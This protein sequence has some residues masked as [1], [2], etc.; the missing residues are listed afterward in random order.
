M[1]FNNETINKL[2]D[3]RRITPKE[4]DILFC[5]KEDW[6]KDSCQ[7]EFFKQTLKKII[8]LQQDKKTLD[9]SF[10]KFSYFS[11]KDSI[12]NLKQDISFRSAIFYTEASFYD[13]TFE[14]NVNF[15]YAMFKAKASFTNAVFKA[16]AFFYD[17]TFEA[18]AIFFNTTFDSI[19]Y[20]YNTTFKA[21]ADLKFATFKDWANFYNTTFEALANFTN[22]SFKHLTLTN[23]KFNDVN[24]LGLSGYENNQ[25]VTLSKKHFANKES[26]RLIKAYFEKQN[27]ISEANKY[28]S[29]EQELYIDH[30]HKTKT[31]P[32]RIPTLATLYLNKWVS[33]FGTDWIRP[34]LV[35]FIFGYLASLGYG[36][37]QN[38]DESINFTN[39]KLLLFSGFLYS[40]LVYYF[41]DKKLWIALTA[42]IIV[43]LSMLMGDIH[44][45][46]ISN[47]ISKLINPLNIFKPKVNYFDSIAMYGMLVKLGMSV[48]IYQFIMA[49]RQNTRRK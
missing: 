11:I 27:N 20:F 39:S 1:R 18:E 48:L 15:D 19:A 22:L 3:E 8:K 14:E 37:L 23:A 45:R 26:A 36:F 35:M 17:T 9:L 40:L 16:N 44:L 38:G 10:I 2:L 25:K 49:F 4:Y 6:N 29:I 41:Y 28:F 13:A 42:S 12:G 43:F 21:E 34:L 46:E 7:T 33:D 5:S 31:E 24:F 32:N 30:L 47:D